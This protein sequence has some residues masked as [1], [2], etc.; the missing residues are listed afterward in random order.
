[1]DYTI[2]KSSKEL[3]KI[4]LYKMV[5]SDANISLGGDCEGA[6]ISASVWVVYNTT[7]PSGKD[8]EVLA[9]LDGED[10]KV[11]CTI[12]DTFKRHF[13]D[14]V[15]TFDPELPPIQVIYGTSRNGRKF[16]TCTVA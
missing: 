1:M 8:I 15:K 11:Y 6:I 2:V 16:V 13:F 14:I 7:D 4:E 9:I 3:S 5:V 10:G 12:S